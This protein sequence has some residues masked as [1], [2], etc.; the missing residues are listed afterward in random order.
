MILQYFN[1]IV[2]TYL[3]C[4]LVDCRRCRVGRDCE[5]MDADISHAVWVGLCVALARPG[6]AQTGL[7][8][9]A[10]SLELG[11]ASTLIMREIS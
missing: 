3:D 4:W 2:E 1:D 11:T 5:N 6:F 10:S 7:E 9:R 8:S